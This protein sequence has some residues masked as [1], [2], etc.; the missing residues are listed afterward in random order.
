MPNAKE[1]KIES[2]DLTVY[3][4][5][6]CPFML[7]NIEI[8]QNYFK[9]RNV[10]L[11]LNKVDSLEKAKALPCVFNNFAVFSNGKFITVNL[12]LDTGSLDALELVIL[13]A[14]TLSNS[15]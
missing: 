9:E 10:Q 7:Q 14:A 5:M 11:S 8:I 12:M 15:F 3:Y 4:D 6:Q 13:P 2:H 1:E